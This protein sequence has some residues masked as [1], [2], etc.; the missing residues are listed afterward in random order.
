E[1]SQAGGI[2]DGVGTGDLDRVLDQQ[3]AALVTGNRAAD[4]DEAAG[5]GGGDDLEIL[6]GAVAGP[7]VAG[8]LL[9]LEDAAR[10]LAVAGR[11]VRTVRDRDAVGGAQALEAPALHRAGK[12]LALGH[13]L[14]IDHLAGDEM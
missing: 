11:T 12:A 2:G 14:N 9:V 5:E 4:E 8:H 10:I 13:A 7:H 6:L 3:P 1:L